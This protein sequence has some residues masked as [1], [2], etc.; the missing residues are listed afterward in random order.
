ML[1]KCVDPTFA[2][3]A[4]SPAL[5]DFLGVGSS[6]LSEHRLPL[7]HG[8]DYLVVAIAF[9][10]LLPWLFVLDRQPGLL[11]PILAPCLHFEISDSSLSKTWVHGAWV[12][13]TG[14]KHGLL[15]PEVWARD[16]GFHGRAF[17]GEELALRQMHE[18]TQLLLVEFPVPWISEVALSVGHDNWVTSP[19]W[20]KSWQANPADAMTI[21]PSEGKMYHNPL[22]VR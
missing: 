21:E 19:D 4:T 22:Y 14:Y 11:T 5:L 1:A 2:C 18:L 3:C 9:G 13:A 7:R 15:A 17:D 16:E 12:D 20:S 6:T 10:P 8:L